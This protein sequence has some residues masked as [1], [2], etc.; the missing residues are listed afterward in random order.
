MEVAALALSEEAI[1]RV[2]DTAPGQSPSLDTFQR[3]FYVR[4]V[5]RVPSVIIPRDYNYVLLPAAVRFTAKIL[6][7]EPFRFD[8]RFFAI[9]LM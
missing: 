1:K 3:E 7:V 2:E 5:L 9:D 8:Q 6:W 4:R